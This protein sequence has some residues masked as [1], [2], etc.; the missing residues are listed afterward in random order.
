MQ[1]LAPPANVNLLNMSV[2]DHTQ[3]RESYR[4]EY[5]P[6]TLV[7]RTVSGNVSSHLSGL[8]SW[9]SSPQIA[10]LRFTA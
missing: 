2:I 10:L 7:L 1:D 6:G 3:R 4:W 5:T 9:A 8:N